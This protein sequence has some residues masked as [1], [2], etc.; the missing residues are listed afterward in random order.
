MVKEEEKI[1]KRMRDIYN[2]LIVIA[3]LLLLA[4]W[5]KIKLLMDWLINL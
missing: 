4:N 2:A 3:I 5:D 1:L